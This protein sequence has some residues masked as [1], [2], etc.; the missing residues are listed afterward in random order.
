MIFRRK[1][2]RNPD[3]G[4]VVHC[5][6]ASRMTNAVFSRH[7]LRVFHLAAAAR[8]LRTA[9]L[10]AVVLIAAA[11]LAAPQPQAPASSSAASAEPA[12]ACSM[13]GGWVD[14]KTGSSIRGAELFR[15]LAGRN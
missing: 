13:P 9:A 5:T 6:G 8:P 7:D 4:C 1:I 3:L 12:S 11:G 2:K 14:V 10:S 15:D